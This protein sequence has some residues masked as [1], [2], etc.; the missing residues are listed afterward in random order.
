MALGPPRHLEPHPKP[1]RVFI[2]A[3]GNDLVPPNQLLIPGKLLDLGI[4][5]VYDELSTK[6]GLA[7]RGPVKKIF[8]YGLCRCVYMERGEVEKWDGVWVF[9]LCDSFY[10]AFSFTWVEIARFK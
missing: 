4:N 1:L 6:M 5:Y 9:C 8:R 3:N 10:G 7:L 2:F